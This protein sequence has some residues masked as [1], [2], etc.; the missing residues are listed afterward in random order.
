MTQIVLSIT[1]FVYLE[2]DE[3]SL[4]PFS[5]TLELDCGL[6]SVTIIEDSA[7]TFRYSEFISV[8]SQVD[9]TDSFIITASS[10]DFSHFGVHTPQAIV[11]LLE[12]P[13]VTLTT[14]PFV[15][16]IKACSMINSRWIS[17]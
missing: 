15:V 8:S 12:W 1:S 16:E 14:E 4:P 7:L 13:E 3:I 17:E 2:P 9:S 5:H 10:S 6:Q 11:T